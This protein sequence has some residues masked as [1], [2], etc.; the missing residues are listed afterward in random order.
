MLLGV[1]RLGALGVEGKLPLYYHGLLTAHDGT[2]SGGGSHVHISTIFALVN[3]V[4]YAAESGPM[5]S[6]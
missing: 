6:C 5:H 4:P 3:H 1:K 2:V